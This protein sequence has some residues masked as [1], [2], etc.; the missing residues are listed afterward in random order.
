MLGAGGMLGHVAAVH[1][2]EVFAGNAR[3]QARSPTG[4]PQIDQSLALRDAAE[5][6]P[7]LRW[8]DS[9]G[10]AVV[11]NCIGRKLSPTGTI[12]R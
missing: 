12:P 6:E 10:P 9:L 8:L 2:Q 4:I 11:I 1:F 3:F 5:T 7:F